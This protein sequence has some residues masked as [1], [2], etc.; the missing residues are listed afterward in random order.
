MVMIYEYFGEIVSNIDIYIYITLSI[1]SCSQHYTYS[2]FLK[3]NNHI[4]YI[5]KYVM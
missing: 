2:I 1:D 5:H 4:Q 3:Y